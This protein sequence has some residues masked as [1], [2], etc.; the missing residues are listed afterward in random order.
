MTA[1]A[2]PFAYRGDHKKRTGGL[3]VS[4]VSGEEELLECLKLRYA[5]F[6][7]E[8]GAQ[9]ACAGAGVDR[10]RFD[11]FCRHLIV[12]DIDSGKVVGTTRV[13]LGDDAARAGSFYSQTEFDLTR[14]FALPGRFMEVGRTCVHRD[15][16]NGAALGT[17]WAGLAALMVQ[18]DIDYLIG[19]AS[20]PFGDTGRYAA[21]VMSYLTE[22]HYSPEY[23]RVYPHV[24]L[25]RQHT[26]T[27]VDV[28]VPPLLKTYMRLGAVVCGEACWDMEFNVA[29]AFVLLERAR[30]HMGYLRRFVGRGV[31]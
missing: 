9:L 5:V 24:P 3:A 29:D 7:G 13:L 10:D 31:V 27:T 19:C 16:R 15:F 23:M 18:H 8:M 20:I 6:A 2:V 25:R 22:R 28:V 4:L 17:M 30:M 12:T 11:D 21:S 14:V 26:P 1:L